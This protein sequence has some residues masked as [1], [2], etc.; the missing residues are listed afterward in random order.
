MLSQVRRRHLCANWV[1]MVQQA[2]SS[3]KLQNPYKRGCCCFDVTQDGRKFN[4]ARPVKSPA[5][6]GGLTNI[7]ADNSPKTEV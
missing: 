2:A 1:G 4:S 3:D 6:D 5:R 7:A